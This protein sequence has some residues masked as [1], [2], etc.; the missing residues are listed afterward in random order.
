MHNSSNTF[1]QVCSVSI[2]RSNLRGFLFTREL[3]AIF[4]SAFGLTHGETIKVIWFD[5]D[6]MNCLAQMPHCNITCD[7]N[8]V[9]THSLRVNGNGNKLPG[10]GGHPC[11]GYHP[12]KSGMDR[13][14][15]HKTV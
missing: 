8:P 4:Y 13:C 12:E 10:E 6:A 9:C 7:V 3:G 11:N 1:L 5:V 2:V 14:S 15:S